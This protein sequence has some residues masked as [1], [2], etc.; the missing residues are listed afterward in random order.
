M[1]I[2][3][4]RYLAG[5]YRLSPDKRAQIL[6]K[7]YKTDGKSGI[8]AFAIVMGVKSAELFIKWAELDFKNTKRNSR[9]RKLIRIGNPP[10]PPG[11]KE[12]N[13]QDIL[14]EMF[15]STGSKIGKQGG[16]RTI[17]SAQA[18]DAINRGGK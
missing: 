17:S 14:E 8:H 11:Q 6:R 10:A 4:I 13:I 15:V 1:S 3:M 7:I 5:Q 9:G 12:C 18:W 2:R 16:K